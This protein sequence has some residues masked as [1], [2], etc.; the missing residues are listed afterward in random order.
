MLHDSA[1]QSESI[2][3]ISVRIPIQL[4]TEFTNQIEDYLLAESPR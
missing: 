1:D 3:G 4:M 2:R